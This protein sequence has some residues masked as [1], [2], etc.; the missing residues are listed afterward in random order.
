MSEDKKQRLSA[1]RKAVFTRDRFRCKKCGYQS[2]PDKAEEEL[3]SHHIISR[4]DMPHGGY[5]KENGISLCKVG[6]NCHLKAENV[7]DGFDEDTLFRLIGSS[8]LLAIKRDQ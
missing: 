5:V 8:K 4:D 2:T 7:E 1:F 6:E 3:D